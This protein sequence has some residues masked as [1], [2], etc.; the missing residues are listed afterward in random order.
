MTTQLSLPIYPKVSSEVIHGDCLEV[1]REM[2]DNSI[3]FIVTDPPYGLHFMGKK[4]DNFK[5]QPAF[6]CQYWQEAL[7]ICKPGSMVAAFGGDR[8]H[9]HLMY[10]LEVS[11]W[12]IRTCIYWITGQGFPKSHNFGCK[13]KGV[14][15]PYNHE[16]KE[17]SESFLRPLS[18]TNLS[19]SFTISQTENE[20]LFNG[21]QEQNTQINRSATKF[22]NEN[23][24][25]PCLEGRS[26]LQKDEGE[27]Y[28]TEVCEMSSRMDSNGKERRL[29]NGTPPCNGETY[30]SDSST[31]RS[32]SSQGSQHTEQCNREFGTIRDE[33]ST[34][35]RRGKTCETCKGII[36]FNGYGTALKPAAEIIVL[37]MKPL[38]GTFAQN[39][40]KW[41]VAGIN[42]ESSRIGEDQITT[43][44]G[45]KFPG[46]YGDYNECKQSIHKGR[47]PASL[48]LDE[49]SAAELDRMTGVSKSSGHI[50]HNSKS[51]FN[52]EN[53]KETSGIKD[54]GG[55]SRFF[56]VAK[57]SSSERNRGLEGMP[58]KEACHRMND[59]LL[60]M[61]NG[62]TT[63]KRAPQSKNNNTHPTIK[64]IALMKY[65]IKL[66]A[67]PGNPTLLDPFC[68]SG[69]TLVA[70]KEL[71]IS[72]I[73]IEKEEEY[74]EIAK[75]RL[76]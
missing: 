17:I 24:K 13:C 33:S 44:E 8:T 32:S 19:A 36:G 27:L 16:S 11:G 73:G 66:L 52:N 14:P 69:S 30:E 58:L 26:N 48:I 23:G 2:A 64:P 21:M 20:I 39:A 68:G 60:R 47:W 31:N 57:A 76:K 42:I 56:Y 4:F 74:V 67:P 72:C 49:E 29:Y 9:H 70:A 51:I 28:R 1:M 54:R 25:E 5:N 15:V 38:D 61:E 62:K 37:A 41:G 75:A 6:C 34:Q 46:I 45:N 55:A 50:R 43:R 22:R 7:R 10:A 71:G 35:D 18:N 63:G 65:I 3:D 40:E 12:E 53:I 59:S